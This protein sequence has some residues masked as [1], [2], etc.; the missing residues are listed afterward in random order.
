MLTI[1][2]TYKRKE[3]AAELGGSTIDFL[4]M[5]NG[6]VVCACLREELNPSAPKIILAGFGPQREKSA[7][8][9]SKQFGEIPVFIKWENKSAWEYVGDFEV[10]GSSTNPKEI[11]ERDNR[12][13]RSEGIS[14]IIY[15]REIS[16]NKSLRLRAPA[17]NN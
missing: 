16:K 12:K 9:L 8:I 4:P 13:N 11:K 17:V 2:K 1:G 5:V 14:R 10:E 15:L 6:K 7:A 3:I